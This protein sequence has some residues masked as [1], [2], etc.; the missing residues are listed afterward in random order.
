VKYAVQTGLQLI[1]TF[2]IDTV[3][4]TSPPHSSQLIGLKLKQRTGVRWIVDFRD[5]WT[6]VYYYPL[7]NHS[8]LSAWIDQRYEQR[9]IEYC[10]AII[11]VSNGFK[12]IFARKLSPAQAQKISVIPNGYDAEDFPPVADRPRNDRFTFTYTGTM[13][14][15]YDPEVVFQAIH[16][17][18]GEQQDLPFLLKLV[19]ML[20][21]ELVDRCTELGIPFEHVPTVPLNGRRRH[22][23]RQT[24]R[25][26]R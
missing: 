23:T 7:L 15:Q 14:V 18:L 12:D 25:V 24:I 6:D 9:V 19:G 22:R 5:P 16:E 13:S 2:G 20:S 8:R 21:S 4:T 3:I 10:D 1:E 17:L 11:T 26:P